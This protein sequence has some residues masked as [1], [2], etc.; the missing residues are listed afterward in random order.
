MSITLNEVVADK[1]V[2]LIIAVKGMKK[3]QFLVTSLL[4]SDARMDAIG[5]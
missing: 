1:D 3:D 4:M 5:Q 2:Q